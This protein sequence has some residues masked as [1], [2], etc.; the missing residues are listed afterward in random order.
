MTTITQSITPLPAVPDPASMSPAMFSSTA[1]AFVLAQKAEAVELE[2]FRGQVNTV[3]G[4]M[5]TNAGTASSAAIN[6]AASAA[7]AAATSGVTIWVSGTTYAIG[8]NR[9][10]PINFLTYRRKTIG[11]G[12]TDPSLDVANWASVLSSGLTVV[13][14][15]ATT[16]AAAAGNQYVLTN[17]AASTVTL[18]ASPASGDTVWVTVTNGLTTNIIARNGQTIM[19]VAEDMTVDNATVTVELRFVNSSWRL[20]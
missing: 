16:Q 10:S 4:E 19:G 5:A 12:A 6:A 3:A 18:P 7:S 14:V 9:F 11:A 20:V 2:T 8:D 17:V 1:A 15:S 13:V